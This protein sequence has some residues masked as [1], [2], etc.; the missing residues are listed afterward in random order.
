MDTNF[1]NEND[2]PFTSKGYPFRKD[3]E[4]YS[5]LN[6]GRAFFSDGNVEKNHR[7]EV[8]DH[9]NLLNGVWLKDE[10]LFYKK[11]EIPVYIYTTNSREELND[12]YNRLA[13]NYD[14]IALFFLKEEEKEHIEISIN[15]G[16]SL[17]KL[18]NLKDEKEM[19]NK[20][21]IISSLELGELT[22]FF[23]AKKVVTFLNKNNELFNLDVENITGLFKKKTPVHF[24][25]G[26][27]FDGT[28]NN[29]FNSEKVYYK[30]LNSSKLVYSRIPKEKK[31][32]DGSIIQND[33]S[34]WNPYSNVALLYDLY[35]EKQ[36]SDKE[37]KVTLKLYIQGIGT[38]EG[39]EDDI[40][41]SALGEGENGIIGKVA[42]GCKELAEEIKKV[43]G[44]DNEIGS[45][46]FDVFG[47]SRG[48]AAARHFCNEI[49]GEENV[50]DFFTKS[51]SDSDSSQKNQGNTRVKNNLR[52]IPIGKK[53]TLG[54]L[55]LA[56]K[57][58]R[59][60]YEISELFT[61]TTK[62]NIRFLGIFDTVVSQ[63]LIKNHFGKKL[64]LLSPVTKIP[65]GVGTSI[66][67]KFD[68]VKQKIDNLPIKQVVH[69][70]AED[71]WREN[72]ALTKAGIGK[73]I[74]EVNLPGTHSDIGGGYAAIKEDY[75]IIDYEQ[76]IIDKGEE[77]KI[78]VRLEK[79]RSFL[80][81]N[82]F[83]SSDEIFYRYLVYEQRKSDTNYDKIEVIDWQIIAKRKIIPRYSIVNMYIM[84]ELAKLYGIPF[85]K[86]IK[87]TPFSFEYDTPKL[88]VEYQKE[89]IEKLKN[90]IQ[91]KVSKSLKNKILKNKFIH[92]SSNYNSSKLFDRKGEA[93]TGIKVL[94]KLFYVNSPRY[95]NGSK[96]SYLR[97]NYT[98]NK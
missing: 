87:E 10:S 95:E 16:D 31:L 62:V 23:S 4:S 85:D 18:S 45:V 35:D 30:K 17:L 14:E 9:I 61:E 80:L 27:F 2:N 58:I 19:E 15:L 50:K 65:F 91:K 37:K 38:Q 56:L 41:G 6:L 22:N 32:E 88:L 29:R 48:A 73:H 84:K 83:G 59:S 93:I 81:N 63:M 39:K 44:N 60:Q 40:L 82:Q 51:N 74:F 55:G 7:F 52:F 96:D 57:D 43:L 64:D 92:L 21:W 86:A 49:I 26:M 12:K 79:I 25:I 72:F 5:P 33:S 1:K 36:Y 69:L 67:T 42:E 46:T 97:E 66:E 34:Y 70:I 89:I 47:F 28:G 53:Y 71:E 24:T 78:P 94:D 77:R 20:R 76:T 54:L 90:E 8:F 98:S 3:L 75:D 11:L 68:V 13:I